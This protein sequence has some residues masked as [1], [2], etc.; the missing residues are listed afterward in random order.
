MLHPSQQRHAVRRHAWRT[1]LLHVA[2]ITVAVEIVS[3][4]FGVHA[5]PS[6]AGA[7]FDEALAGPLDA[8]LIRRVVQAKNPAIRASR[9]RA[10]AATESAAAETRLP[11][12]EA[13]VELWQVPL[14]RPWAIPD[15]GML[16]LGLKQS[17]PAPGVRSA[18]A[19]AKRSEASI[20]A[21]MAEDRSREVSRAALHALSDIED[22]HRRLRVRRSLRSSLE[23][24]VSMARARV[25]GGGSISD[26]AQAELEVARLDVEIA[27]DLVAIA[28]AKQRLNTLL[29]RPANAALG[30]P[31]ERDPETVRAP[32]GDEL[33]RVTASR[34]DVAVVNA[35]REARRMEIRVM[36][37]EASRPE[38]SVGVL[39]FAPVGE[40]GAHG[41][42]ASFSMSLPWVWA[43][44]RARADAGRSWLRAED[45]DREAAKWRARVE[46]V[47]AT[48]G[49]DRA[50]SRLS[51]IRSLALPAARR[52]V[53]IAQATYQGGK[54][55][56]LG[57]LAAQRALSEIELDAANAQGALGHTIVDA[58]A[59]SGSVLPRTPLVEQ[60][61]VVAPH[62]E[63]GAR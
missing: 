55:D 25:A 26:V 53:E 50:T 16:S 38:F 28:T 27:T 54:G 44:G 23:R 61:A 34:P 48:T 1:T 40:M 39:Y 4:P 17:F 58:D 8:A 9:A 60:N 51:A 12:P 18:R 56:V 49:V 41:Y 47:E 11:P 21:A 37:L 43:G 35:T 19:D 15:A 33:E 22:S 63:G 45:A 6:N 32:V 62:V 5:Q 46:V 20:D 52:A 59:A 30:D 57:L 29:D 2:S 14:A 31:I 3:V 24:V 42:G 7:E 13:M 10:Q 36:D